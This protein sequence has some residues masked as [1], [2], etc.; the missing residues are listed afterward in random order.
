MAYPTFDEW[1]AS[2]SAELR[3]TV[4][5]QVE[6]LR[7]LGDSEPELTVRSEVSENF[8][9]RAKF[10]LL[11]RIWSDAIEPWRTLAADWIGRHIKFE[12]DDPNGYFADAGAALKRMKEAGISED[13]IASVAR[14]VAYETAFSVTYLLDYGCDEDAPKHMPGWG[15][16]E[17]DE[18]GDSTGRDMDGLHESILSADPS[19]REGRVR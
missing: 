4:E 17:T 19:G 5:Q 16:F 10:L 14:M 6:E 3:A 15:L 8:P 9:Q 13:D 12:E 7:R 1:K 2:L 18:K 11:R